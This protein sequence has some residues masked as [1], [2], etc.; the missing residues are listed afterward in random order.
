ML[1]SII[2]YDQETDLSL[3]LQKFRIWEMFYLF[4]LGKIY[5]KVKCMTI[6]F[7]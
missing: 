3:Y 6:L 5:R 4:L 7:S 1:N 2:Q